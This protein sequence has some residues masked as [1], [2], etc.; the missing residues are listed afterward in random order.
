[1][2]PGEENSAGR[3]R[4]AVSAVREYAHD[5]ARAS[6]STR[7][8]FLPRNTLAVERY[9]VPE[10]AHAL[11]RE[12]EHRGVLPPDECSVAVKTGIDEM[13]NAI[14]SL[15]R[16][17]KG[18][19]IPHSCL[20]LHCVHHLLLPIEEAMRRLGASGPVQRVI[21]VTWFYDRIARRPIR[22]DFTRFAS[23]EISEAELKSALLFTL[24]QVV[25]MARV[26]TWS[27][28][29]RL[30]TAEVTADALGH[31]RRFEDKDWA[32]RHPRAFGEHSGYLVLDRLLSSVEGFEL[33]YSRR[34]A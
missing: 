1:M 12:L 29:R 30:L 19:P 6:G 32:A 5:I 27:L 34:S 33:P 13:S 17:G 24:A 21:D 15:R 25:S 20:A 18:D 2:F 28:G 7:Y 4:H 31:V 8:L 23:R 9:G 11:A 3:L 14:A 22:N 10:L 26:G 16:L